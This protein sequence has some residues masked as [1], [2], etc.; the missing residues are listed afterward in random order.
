M[1]GFGHTPHADV[2]Y[3]SL[4]RFLLHY[5]N[6]AE[7]KFHHSDSFQELV[8]PLFKIIDGMAE[9]PL[10]VRL[11]MQEYLANNK[12]IAGML[13]GRPLEAIKEM[14]NL[15][16]P[17]H[18]RSDLFLIKFCTCLHPF[19]GRKNNACRMHLLH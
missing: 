9:Y 3:H 13:K 15:C 18:L 12:K 2:F 6:Q 4:L 7:I 1:G 8:G 17:I 19:G 5:I 16:V 14:V 11:E 10:F